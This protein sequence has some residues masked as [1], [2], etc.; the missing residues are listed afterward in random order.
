MSVTITQLRYF[1]EAAARLSMTGAAAELNVAQSAISAAIAQLE[2][3]VGSRLFVRQ[4]AK[5]LILTP[6]GELFLVDAQA[7]LAHL[8]DALD[9][10]RG[11][12]QEVKGK[13]RLVCFTTLAPFFLP[14]L[15]AHLKSRHPALEVDVTE[16][17]A[18]GCAAALLGGRADVA[19]TYDLG[20]PPEVDTAVAATVRPY[21][22]LPAGHRLAG[23]DSVK[24]SQLAN[25]P[26]V[27]LDLPYS[28]DLML[29]TLHGAGLEPK[30]A[31]RS[32]SYETVRTFVGNGH[33]YSILHQRP[34]HDYTYDGSAVRMLEI[35]DDVPSLQMV[36][37][38]R[39]TERPN[40]RVLAAA[41]A[42]FAIARTQ[43]R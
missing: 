20:L 14:A 43:T 35:Q 3:H 31:F 24:L 25:E 9:R 23:D 34:H 26:Y 38:R 1:V 8:E 39:G 19:L 29:S 32:A 33:G 5:G 22:A 41:D 13:V 11:E 10:A 2:K 18:A 4:R 6:E 30:I 28:R 15:V 7:V 12:R 37:A 16:A 27:L 42:L 21:V 36:I 40:A 17:D